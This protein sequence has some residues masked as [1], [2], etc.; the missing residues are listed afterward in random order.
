MKKIVMIGHFGGD[1]H[2]TDGQTVKTL[3]LYHELSMQTN[4][5]IKRIDTYYK[6]KNPLK[7][8]VKML[9]ALLQT[10]KI[11]ILL[12]GNG[13]RIF[14]PVLYFFA[15]VKQSDVYHDVIG[16]NLAQ[17]IIRY[18]KYKKYLNSFS[19]NW[20]ETEKLKVE[21]EEQG[22]MNVAILPNFRRIELMKETELQ[23]VYDEPFHFC[24]FSRVT[25]AKGIEE[26][27]AAVEAINAEEKRSVCCLDI[28]GPVD[29]AYSDRFQS[30][31][32][33][34]TSSIS[35]CGEVPFKEAIPTLKKYYA[36]LFPTRW[37]G[38]SQAG[39]ISESFFAGI[40]VVAT[41]WHCNKEMIQSGYNGILYPSDYARDLKSGIYW[42]IGQ[43][44]NIFEIKKN[45]L[46]SAK[47]YLPDV[48]I[49]MIVNMIE[50]N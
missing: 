44:K 39:T 31:M 43:Y 22:I 3:N 13:M 10:K 27:I 32:K 45:C 5:R 4:W 36:T 37:G 23:R 42:V 12:S 15:K 49:K 35:Y 18:P 33:N 46:E 17:Y 28:Y 34:A 50:G 2:F 47:R 7:L 38:E 29:E 11:I 48:H 6:N 9:V 25:E 14:F 21:L 30:V 24:T 20:V 19:V 26:A 1:K 41:D 40:P 16:G 8:C